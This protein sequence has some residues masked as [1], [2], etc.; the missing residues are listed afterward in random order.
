MNWPC[1]CFTVWYSDNTVLPWGAI[2]EW[3]KVLLHAFPLTLWKARMLQT[4][5]FGRWKILSVAVTSCTYLHYNTIF[6]TALKKSKKML[7]WWSCTAL[8]QRLKSA[9]FLKFLW[10][11]MLLAFEAKII[12]KNF[13]FSKTDF[14]SKCGTSTVYVGHNLWILHRRFRTKYLAKYILYGN[15]IRAAAGWW[16]FF[17]VRQLFG[18]MMIPWHVCCGQ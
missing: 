12:I 8:P 18:A 17:Y 7:I 11:E 6:H 3:K 1:M 4:K 15:R 16:L 14:G 13:L 9:A 10:M 5:P 2:K